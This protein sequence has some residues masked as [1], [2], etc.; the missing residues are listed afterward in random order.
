MALTSIGPLTTVFTPPAGCLST[1]TYNG[2]AI[3]APDVSK[4]SLSPA[5]LLGATGQ[6]ADLLCYPPKFTLNHYYSPGICPSGWYSA[7]EPT[8]SASSVAPD[9]AKTVQCCPTGLNCDGLAWCRGDPAP[10]GP[11]WSLYT[12]KY[13]IEG[14]MT[15]M[16][17]PTLSVMAKPI[18]VAYESSDQDVLA[19]AT[20]AAKTAEP[21]NGANAASRTSAGSLEN[22]AGL[23]SQSS[24]SGDSLSGGTIA[25]IVIGSLGGGILLATIMTFLALRWLGYRKMPKDGFDEKDQSGPWSELGAGQAN[26]LQKSQMGPWNESG[27]GR[28][29]EL[30]AWP[31]AAELPSQNPDK[32]A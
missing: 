1:R 15:D 3:W 8:G 9:A 2:N 10:P 28:A 23:S 19:A 26:E 24:S 17:F 4:G 25:G 30:H 27:T 21:T 22:G 6:A 20:R 18:F 14:K 11:I 13:G 12:D 7:C 31:R 29:N 16:V 32:P 5:V